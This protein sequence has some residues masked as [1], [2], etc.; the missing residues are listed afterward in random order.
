MDCDS[1]HQMISELVNERKIERKHKRKLANYIILC[2]LIYLVFCLVNQFTRY[3]I[4]KIAVVLPP[5]I[6]IIFAYG[7]YKHGKELDDQGGFLVFFILWLIIFAWP[8]GGIY[9]RI[10]NVISFLALVA[11]I[12]RVSK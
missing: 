2:A 1:K 9:W 8:I 5:I 6:T 4:D 7:W 11:F 3:D 12:F 10:S